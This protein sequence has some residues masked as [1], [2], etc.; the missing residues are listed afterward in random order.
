MNHSAYHLFC[1]LFQKKD[2]L[3]S[4]RKIEQFPFD[5]TML[6]CKNIGRFPDLAIRVNKDGSDFTGGELIE[7][8]DSKTLKVSSFNS[9]IPTG[10]KA[11]AG[12]VGGKINSLRAQME[13]AGDEILALPTRQVFYLIR[14]KKTKITKVALVHGKFFET[15]SVPDLISQSF[16]QAL[17]ERLGNMKEEIPGD[18]KATLIKLFIDQDTF[19][20]VRTVN[21]AS[22]K[23]RFRIMT[24]V[25]EEG[26]LLNSNKY[27]E[28][29]D[30][31]L[32]FLVPCHTPEEEEKQRRLMT[33]AF[34]QRGAKR[35]F[36]GLR[37]FTLKHLLN[38]PFLV[39][40]TPI[41]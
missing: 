33:K 34:D 8:K 32:N 40:Q 3:I 12:L 13:M 15:L 17:E 20:R 14:G 26:N 37:I 25:R 31:T 35:L 11:V 9:T 27:P 19:S 16:L 41:K 5:T 28:I 1:D 6:S 39:F 10:Q 7:I 21:K 22:V 23:L 30:N 18:I 4:A 24:E 38:G 29:T 36:K 2:R